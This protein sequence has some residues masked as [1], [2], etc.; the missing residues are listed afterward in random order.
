MR[1]TFS[2]SEE[3]ERQ[4]NQSLLDLGE[5]LEIKID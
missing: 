3:K 4:F 2:S 1:M 5:V